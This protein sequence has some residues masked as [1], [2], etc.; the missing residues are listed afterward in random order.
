MTCFANKKGWIKIISSKGREDLL[1]KVHWR[2]IQKV[3]LFPKFSFRCYC[4]NLYN[5]VHSDVRNC[6][7]HFTFYM[8][9]SVITPFLIMSLFPLCQVGKQSFKCP[10]AFFFKKVSRR[11][12]D[13][14]SGSFTECLSNLFQRQ[15]YLTRSGYIHLKYEILQLT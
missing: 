10:N 14:H 1:L 3:A 11:R 4:F 8:K 9:I 12:K 7:I 5:K 6:T 13:L 15:S 2:L